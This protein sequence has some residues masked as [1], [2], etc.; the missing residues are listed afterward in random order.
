MFTGSGL[1][2]QVIVLFGA[3]GDL[4]KRKLFPGLYRLAA[5]GWLPAEY[6][7][8]GTGRHAPDSDEDF[9]AA[10]AAGIREFVDEVDEGCWPTLSGDCLS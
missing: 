7:V 9:Q 5:A 10:A 6:A 4:A 2:P 8:L 1:P 3:R